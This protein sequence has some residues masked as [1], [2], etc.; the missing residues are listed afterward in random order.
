MDRRNFIKS[1]SVIPFIPSINW[2]GNKPYFQYY[3]G[4]SSLNNTTRLVNDAVE[5]L[6]KYPVKGLYLVPNSQNKIQNILHKIRSDILPTFISNKIRPDSPRYDSLLNI[7]ELS[8]G[9]TLE[10]GTLG[11]TRIDSSY[12][13]FW[14]DQLDVQANKN[15]M[16][17]EQHVVSIQA[18][19]MIQEE[20]GLKPVELGNGLKGFFPK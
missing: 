6:E 5:F 17:H 16:I 7:L 13:A 15:N 2:G 9:G 20:L 1:L 11:F 8:N 10:I 12:K 14:S 19:R 4:P 3:F 18:A